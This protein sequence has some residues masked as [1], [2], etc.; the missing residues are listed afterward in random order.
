M[1][2]WRNY[3]RITVFIHLGLTKIPWHKFKFP[4]QYWSRKFY[5][6]SKKDTSGPN[7]Q[8][9]SGWNVEF[10]DIF[11]KFHF[12]LTHNKFPDNFLTEKILIF[13]TFPWH[14]WTLNY[15]EIFPLNF[16]IFWCRICIYMYGTS[17]AQASLSQF[18]LWVT[19]VDTLLNTVDS[20]YLEFQGTLWN[21]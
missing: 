15:H 17:F 4:W 13:L 20:R 2:T 11:A 19:M 12:S 9:S 1:E 8:A 18:S 21:T 5:E 7:I 6:F 16:N 3:P 14:V 10:P